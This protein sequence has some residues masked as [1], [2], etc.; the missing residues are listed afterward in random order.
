M[1]KFREKKKEE[2]S[3]GIEIDK[4][5]YNVGPYLVP[6]FRQLS[7]SQMSLLKQDTFGWSDLKFTI[8]HK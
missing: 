5:F 4:A 7:K 6:D 1:D 8:I 3:A 2:E